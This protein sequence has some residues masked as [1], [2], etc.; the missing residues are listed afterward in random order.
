MGEERAMEI[1][2]FPVKYYVQCPLTAH[3]VK[4]AVWRGSGGLVQLSH[5]QLCASL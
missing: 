5:A 4:L 3:S 1:K 2:F